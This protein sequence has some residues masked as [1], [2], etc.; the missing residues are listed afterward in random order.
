MC[1][2]LLCIG[3]LINHLIAYKIKLISI[4]FQPRAS[5]KKIYLALLTSTIP[6]FCMETG[7]QDPESI[8]SYE[9]HRWGM[10]T[11]L[12]PQIGSFRLA[13]DAVTLCA[14]VAIVSGSKR[15][16]S[17]D[18]NFFSTALRLGTAL[19]LGCRALVSLVDLRFRESNFSL[20]LDQQILTTCQQTDIVYLVACGI[21]GTTLG[22]TIHFG[23][24]PLQE[25]ALAL[26]SGAT[27]GMCAPALI[28]MTAAQ[29]IGAYKKRFSNQHEHEI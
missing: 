6:V 25:N 26:A 24:E 22:A 23:D 7:Q 19:G 11:R 16:A 3:L 27:V 2:K 1:K 5:M 13:S 8:Q 28:S 4:N 29:I 10:A 12:M 18:H 15:D 14:A 17:T 21:M 9:E 20:Q